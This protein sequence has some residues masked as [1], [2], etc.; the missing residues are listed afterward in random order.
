[1]QKVDQTAADLLVHWSVGLRYQRTD[2]DP[3][4]QCGAGFLAR[5]HKHPER[6]ASPE[7]W[8]ALRPEASP[9]G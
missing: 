5:D 9:R 2:R 3:M 4:P 1:M 7:D 8:L 6:V